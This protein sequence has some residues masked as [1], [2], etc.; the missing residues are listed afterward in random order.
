MDIKIFGKMNFLIFLVINVE[1]KT[2]NIPIKPNNIPIS[3]I[4]KPT[5]SCNQTG[6]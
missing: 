4:S 2:F 3:L 6:K 1:E 5:I